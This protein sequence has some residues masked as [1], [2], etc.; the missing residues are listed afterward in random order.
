MPGTIQDYLNAILNAKY[1]EQVRDAIYH[2]IDMCYSDVSTGTTQIDA[3]ITAAGTATNDA[4]TAA[5]DAQS[6]SDEWYNS[7]TNTGLKKTIEAAIDS[8]NNPNTGAY[9]KAS[10]VASEWY[11]TTTNPPT[12]LKVQIETA[13]NNANEKAS[14][15]KACA[16]EWTEAY[17]GGASLRSRILSAIDEANTQ[18]DR[19]ETNANTADEKATEAEGKISLMNSYISEWTT[20]YGQGPGGL[21]DQIVA[22]RNLASQ[23]AEAAE[24]AIN[25][26]TNLQVSAQDVGSDE[27]PD[28]IY[29]S[30]AGTLLFK[31]KQGQPGVPFKVLGT[32]ESLSDLRT[33]ISNPSV[34]D[35]YNIG[36]SAPYHVYRYTGLEDT[37]SDEDWEDEG[38]IGGG[39]AS[40][41][42]LTNSEIDSI[43]AGT[44][45]A[46]TPYKYASQTGLYQLRNKITTALTGKVDKATGYGLSKNDF[47]DAYK[48]LVDGHTTTIG[49][50][51]SSIDSLQTSVSSLSTNKVDKVSGKGLSKNDFTDAY[52]AA[53]DTTIPNSISAIQPTTFTVTLSV[54][55][56]SNNQQTVT[57]S[58]FKSSGKAYMVEP[59]YDSR[60][61][62][63]SANVVAKNVETNNQMIFTCDSVPSGNLTVQILCI[64]VS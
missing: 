40:V 57:N 49:D 7:L 41:T 58:G 35:M 34:G 48:T 60:N 1:G 37:G 51:S 27:A 39:Q 22:A 28:A 26:I 62:Y 33:A 50:H 44:Q 16:D 15:A 5:S 31:L 54:G 4:I 18:A 20:S 46:A 25:K 38:T 43:W 45:P 8:I 23:K 9:V 55:S 19:A 32:Y 24:S 61:A 13:K 21:R 12:G 53:L 42:N 56:W 59:D 52:K 2:S 36:S 10:R 14:L 47:S 3:A 64:G 29:N 11:D 6:A 63:I 17:S 30:A